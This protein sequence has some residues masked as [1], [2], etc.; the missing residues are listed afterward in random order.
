MTAQHHKPAPS[1]R[2]QTATTSVALL[3]AAAATVV[4]AVVALAVVA[5]T[6]Q[7]ASKTISGF[8]GGPPIGD[9]GA[10]GGQFGSPRDVAVYT[11]NDSDPANDKIFVVEGTD[12]R[13]GD[14]GNNRVQRL[15]VHGNFELMWGR[16]VVITGAPGDTGAGFEVC[17]EAVGG[18]ASCKDGE[19][20]SSEGEFANPHGVAVDQ[21]TGHVFVSDRYN[22]R[23]QEFDLDGGF[24]RAWGW[25]VATGAEAFEVCTADCRQGLEGAGDGQ[26]TSAEDPSGQSSDPF[27]G[28]G[29]AVDPVNGD[30]FVADPANSRVQQFT[31]TG[32]FVAAFG[33]LDDDSSFGVGEFGFGEP[34]RLTVDSNHIVYISD[35]TDFNDNSNRVQ[36]YD[37]DADVF[38]APIAGEPTPGAPLVEGTTVG[39]EIDPDSDGGG[40][41]EE[42]LFVARDRFDGDTV[43]QELDIPTPPTDP[44]TVVVDNHVYETDPSSP[45]VEDDRTVNGIG[46]SPTSG[47]LFLV[48]PGLITQAGNGTFTG[49]QAST[50]SGLIVLSSNSGPLDASVDAANAATTS[51]AVDGI[52]NA[53]GGVASYR[54]E[55]STDGATWQDSGVG[56]YV[57]GLDDHPV[58]GELTGLDP[59]TFYRVRLV[60][61][62]QTGITTDVTTI[63]NELVVLTDAAP[64]QVQT[65]GSTQRTDHSA[66]LRGR[67]D[68]NGAQ[69]TYRFEY[70]PAGGSFDQHVPIPDAS[71]GSGQSLD[72]VVADIDGLLPST[73]YQYRIV[74]TNFVG[75]SVGETVTLTTEPSTLPTPPPGRGYE[76]VSPAHKVGGV[77]VGAWYDGPGQIGPVGTAAYERE[78]FAA[79]G[80]TGSV[81]VDGAY[82]Y[83]DDWALAQRTP[84]GWTSSPATSRVAHGS[85]NFALMGIWAATEDLTLTS[86]TSNGHVFK[87]FPEMEPW[88]GS[89]IGQV[90]MVRDWTSGRWELFGP[91]DPAQAV[92][93][94]S[95]IG[96]T[97]K[98][99]A[100]DGSAMVSHSRNVRGLAGPGD[101]TNPAFPDLQSGGSVYLDEVTG[102]FSDAFPGDDGERELVNV[103]TGDGAARTV[104]PSVDGSGK[105]EGQACPPVLPDLPGRDARLISPRGAAIDAVQAGGQRE[106]AAGAVSADGS[107]VL[108]MSPDPHAGGGAPCEG[109][110]VDSECP[111][112]LFVWQRG[113]GGDPVT[114][115][116]SQS[117]IADQDASLMAPA[118]FEGAS[119]DGDKVFFRTASPLTADDPNGAGATPPAGGVTTGVPDPLSWD[120]YMYDLP[121]GPDGDPSTPDGDPA[122]GDLVRI[123]AGPSNGADC[124]S[125]LSGSTALR[126]VSA[127]A[128]RAYFTCAAALPG[129]PTPD[130][131][132]IISPGG[133]AGDGAAANLYAYDTARPAALRWRFVA[134][135]PRTSDLGRC[136]TVAGGRGSVIGGRSG[137][138]VVLTSTFNCVRG[139]AD[140]SLV[141]FFTDGQLTADDPD[142]VSGDVYAYDAARDE[143]TRVSAPQG[144]VGGTYPCATEGSDAPCYGDPGIESEIGSVLHRLGVATRPDGRRL[145]FFESRSRLVADDTDQA[146]DVYQWSDG[147][148]SLISTGATDDPDGVFYA[149]NDR[150]GLN[151]YL[152]TREQ[153]TWQDK[154]AVL[155]VYSARIGGGIPEPAP[156]ADCDLP[157]D[158]CQ[159]GGAGPSQARSDSSTPADGNLSPRGRVKVSIVGLSRRARQRAART[160]VLA[161]RL[162]ASGPGVVLV[163]ARARLGGKAKRV[164]SARKRLE[165]TGTATVRLRL[166][167][168]ARRRLGAGRVLV[169]RVSARPE[170]ARGS[171]IDVTLKRSGR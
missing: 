32:D 133:S 48:T 150:S 120:L 144:G 125:G 139:S 92:N 98:E 136:A 59:N 145:V 104:L 157:T 117:E 44:V 39:L 132:T 18:A 149:G 50:C 108:F 153:L 138:D 37:A 66:R 69:T 11:A 3:A 58:S 161:V 83:G 123:S 15:D 63:S 146:Y 67:V 95:P 94:N 72:L 158:S 169:L 127:D 29:I 87:F 6:A 130:D 167:R 134:R 155:D 126:F 17:S 80:H 128:S 152:A 20:G 140:G 36:R 115:W 81:L 76:L 27:P 21:S 77:G 85:Q 147:E 78:R 110:G 121:D 91:L 42:H 62:K 26:F 25:G 57:S 164:A 106:D 148:L 60:V 142:A 1:I 68:P 111:T 107:R 135:L 16:D 162:R 5:P 102:A 51:I 105:L 10:P 90:M 116:I 165:A 22:M 122:G 7:A 86:Y 54:F 35:A 129:V 137:G 99:F 55:L 159:S 141:T 56:G 52:A 168:P 31:A 19:R 40:P 89:N 88:N 170:G 13:V 93:A 131:G 163:S 143:L 154:D 112:Q 64:P 75:T 171:A 23:V 38:L 71:A 160:G 49:C 30:V 9:A 47:D 82:A 103:C 24:V 2:R 53:G 33:V 61:R 151:V 46:F 74:A 8:I 43:V 96:S 166:S 100:A 119:R 4:L 101:P 114:R 109:T 12:T 65:L 156:P 79:A 34:L 84:Q 41:D 118:L 73:T 124:N 45:R 97:P 28:T 70:G 113:P 14:S